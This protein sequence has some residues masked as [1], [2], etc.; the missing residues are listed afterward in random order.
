MVSNLYNIDDLA[1][2]LKILM[3]Y[4]ASPFIQKSLTINGWDERSSRLKERFGKYQTKS[5]KGK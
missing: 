1:A 2:K 4:R 5:W 3:V